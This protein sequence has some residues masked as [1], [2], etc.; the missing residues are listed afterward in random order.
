[1]RRAAGTDLNESEISPKAAFK[2][3]ASL[4]G[5]LFR[6]QEDV[7]VS[8]TVRPA[9]NLLVGAPQG[10]YSIFRITTK[11]FSELCDSVLDYDDISDAHLARADEEGWLFILDFELITA[12]G[13]NPSPIYL[14][15]DLLIHIR[16]KIAQDQKTKGI[17]A[18]VA[19]T[20]GERFARDLGFSQF[21][22]YIQRT[23]VNWKLYHMGKSDLLTLL[24]KIPAGNLRLLDE[25]GYSSYLIDDRRRHA[26]AGIFQVYRREM[27][28]AI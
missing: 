28:Q 25:C 7:W 3:W 2:R 27:K 14:L 5:I 23:G 20:K 15:C 26:M 24:E 21:E 18:L 16:F 10:F 6:I 9:K 11:A 19:T 12:K 1:L 22:N 4:N 13:Y 17:A 8:E